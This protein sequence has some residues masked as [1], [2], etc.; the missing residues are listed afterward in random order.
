MLRGQESLQMYKKGIDVLKADV[1]TYQ[2]AKRDED[3][4]VA[5]R[6]I[7]SAYASIADIYMTDMW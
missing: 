7:G 4:E 6:H 1:S 2:I 5:V 3:I